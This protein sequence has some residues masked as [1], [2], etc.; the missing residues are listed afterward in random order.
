MLYF[1]GIDQL[2]CL[3]MAPL[4][5]TLIFSIVR[6]S[7]YRF[8]ANNDAHLLGIDQLWGL[9]MDPFEGTLIQAGAQTT[10]VHM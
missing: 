3:P 5:G 2:L 9:P 4:E 7:G 6:K 8:F 10:I 1:F